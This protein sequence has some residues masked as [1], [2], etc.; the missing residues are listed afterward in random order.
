MKNLT[1][2]FI[3]LLTYFIFGSSD[4][5]A[6]EIYAPDGTPRATTA[7][8]N[9][10]GYQG[11][12]HDDE[13]NL[14]YKRSRYY[15]T[16]Q[17]RFISRDLIEYSDGMNLYQYVGGNPFTFND[18]SGLAK[19]KA[20]AEVVCDGAGG[21]KIKYYDG[22]NDLPECVKKIITAH[23][24]QHMD[25]FGKHQ[26]NACRKGGQS[27]GKALPADSSVK[28]YKE[29]VKNGSKARDK[30]WWKEWFEKRAY[31]DSYSKAQAYLK[32]CDHGNKDNYIDYGY[33]DIEWEIGDKKVKA[34]RKIIRWIGETRKCCRY[35]KKHLENYKNGSETGYPDGSPSKGK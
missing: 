3:I 16:N 12:Y 8:E 18:P 19:S 17:G 33:C 22:F 27:H 34:K 26:K 31:A 4:L 13:S 14:V 30:H 35:L 11:S 10:L 7:I 23:E 15:S 21:F 24:Q 29:Q 32:K 5:Q 9:Q 28:W 2:T 6:R 25:D 1:F 20:Q